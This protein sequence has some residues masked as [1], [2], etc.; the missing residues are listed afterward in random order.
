MLPVDLIGIDH[1]WVMSMTLLESF[2]RILECNAFIESVKAKF[3]HE[4][5]S[6]DYAL[7]FA[8]MDLRGHVDQVDACLY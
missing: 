6:I 5:E 8:R 1:S 3:F 7:F 2:Q 4:G